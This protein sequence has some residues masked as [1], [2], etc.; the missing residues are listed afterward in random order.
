MEIRLIN[1]N[2]ID[3]KI[4]ELYNQLSKTT[5]IN[6]ED[7]KNFVGSLNEY[8][9]ILVIVENNNI[10]GCATYLIENKLIRNVSKVMHI[11]DVVIDCNSRGKKLGKLLIDSLKNKAKDMGCYK[12]ILDCSE[13]NSIFYEKCGFNK[14]G[15]QMSVYF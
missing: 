1:E 14:H 9:N 11:E 2:D 13:E 7:F 10:I 5:E 15:N 4:I 3:K 12:V 8:H 6:R